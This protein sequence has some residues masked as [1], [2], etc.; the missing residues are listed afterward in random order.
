[1]RISL[2][3]LGTL[4]ELPPE[5]ELVDGLTFAGLPVDEV[6]RLGEGLSGVVV[7]RILESRPHPKADRLS[8]T[9]VD[10]GGEKLQIVCGAKNYRVGDLVPLARIGAVL[11][12]GHR[13]E[14]AK[15]RGV[16]SSGMLCSQK[17]LA[18]T[19]DH[20]GLWILPPDVTPGA[21]LA[22][23][24]GLRDTVLE[25]DLTPNRGDCLSHLG[26]AREVAA[27]FD[28]RLKPS[29]ASAA[30][31]GYAGALPRLPEILEPTRCGRYLG[32]AVSGER[33][34]APSP[35]WM[36]ARLAACGVRA[37]NLAVDVTNTVLLELGQPLHAF[38][39][40]ALKEGIRVRRARGGERLRTLDGT[41]RE[42]APDDLLICDGERPLALAGVMGGAES[43]VG[44]GTAALYLEAAWFEPRGIARTARRH[45]LR[46]ESSHR[47]ER[48]VDPELPERA[49]ARALDLLEAAG[50]RPS[51]AAPQRA[52]GERP[53]RGAVVL[54]FARVGELLGAEVPAG[55][56]V[57]LLGRLGLAASERSA[58]SARFSIPSHRFDLAH[59]VELV[60]E[61]A[62]LRGYGSIPPALPA[63]ALPPPPEA[64]LARPLAAVRA[65]LEAHGFS[66]AVNYAFL[67][68]RAAEPF[69]APGA[70]ALQNPL[71]AE[72]SRLR[73]SLLPGLC[74][75]LHHNLA[76]AAALA[77]AA[78]AVRLYELGRVYRWPEA[79]ESPE[80]P[81]VER[82][83][84]SC[85]AYG[86]RSPVGWATA[87]D[88]F[89]F[90]DLR[91]AIDSLV[92]GLGLAAAVARAEAPFL[93][94]RSAAAL[95]ISGRAAGLFGELHPEAARALDLPP[96]V[97]VAELD[98]Q[99]LAEGWARP[100]HTALPRFPALLRDIALV[101]PEAVSA[102]EVTR[103][104]REA[105]GPM[106]E[107]LV[108]FD[109]YRGPPLE[110]G[111]KSLAFSLR[112]RAPDR[113]LED[114]EATT[115]QAALVEAA[116]AQLGAAL[117]T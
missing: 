65:A 45:G 73:G 52:E 117:R 96:G 55:E 17:E 7:A 35:H 88:T 77:G 72:Q 31:A 98:A 26:V 107:T 108:L 97:F 1:M 67:S 57:A 76:H 109:V 14:A 90:A 75:N 42:L 93:H 54:R 60:E 113:T 106:L 79:G 115:V 66:E 19:E 70:V 46:S 89:D 92:E 59:E 51:A 100:R 33:L 15:L 10:A 81:V 91:G 4:V 48:G 102:A 80:G 6:E 87:R 49:L 86:A 71:K 112:L 58:A 12:D 36:A 63:R 62:R 116:R 103:L 13:I 37:I 5:K 53:A 3:W 69:P 43:A 47:F 101:V 94:P 18:I 56:A 28:R 95:S 11:P 44:E 21:P 39:L 111:T 85:V 40:T 114:A 84:L 16:E 83:M 50:A 24:L 105:G 25:L 64:P 32:L 99:A 110:P 27:I 20:E 61:I 34:T 8:V 23:A 30:T 2:A 9:T 78:P 104:L 82:A 22:D 38:D 41:V 68:G 74:Q 29:P